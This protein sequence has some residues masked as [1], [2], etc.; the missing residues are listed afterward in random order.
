MTDT[1]STDDDT[2]VHLPV[3]DVHAN[4]QD[5]KDFDDDELAELGESIRQ[6]GLAQPITVRPDPAGGYVIVAGERRWRAHKLIG[7]STIK[8]LVRSDLNEDGAADVQLIENV[9]RADLDPFEE[10]EAYRA[11]MERFGLND[12]QCAA[13]YGK[14]VA[15]V[16]KRLELLAL[17]PKYRA[18]VKSG[19]LSVSH[20]VAMARLDSNRQALAFAAFEKA[21]GMTVWQFVKVCDG[22]HAEMAADTMFDPDAFLRVEEIVA[23]A[24]KT[25]MISGRDLVHLAVD[26]ADL[27]IPIA[28][29][30]PDLGVD[31]DRMRDLLDM[32]EQ[33]RATRITGKAKATR[34]GLVKGG[35]RKAPAVR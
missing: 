16:R 28:D 3:D 25:A 22:L 9:N 26:L 17:E 23:E 7:A 31:P 19:D 1:L 30:L 2:I 6:H 35:K 4:P 15:L 10:A 8:S 27:I 14:P 20:A 21:H 18:L 32:A 34:S 24:R 11:R 33:L 12:E 29:Q 5:R 13:R